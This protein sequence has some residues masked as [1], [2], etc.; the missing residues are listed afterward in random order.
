MIRKESTIVPEQT[1]RTRTRIPLPLLKGSFHFLVVKESPEVGHHSIQGLSILA[2]LIGYCL[3]LHH[4][5][6]VDP[7]MSRS[8]FRFEMLSVTLACSFQALPHL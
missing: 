4:L 2:I 6:S 7:L 8:N 5:C 3:V 1:E